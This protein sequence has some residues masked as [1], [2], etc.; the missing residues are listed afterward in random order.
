VIERIEAKGS[1]FRSIQDL[2]DTASQQ[3]KFTLQ[4]LADPSPPFLR[5]DRSLILNTA[6]VRRLV[7]KDRNSCL[8]TLEGQEYPLV[9]GRA[10]L[11]R[12]RAALTAG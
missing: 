3:G 1:F 8:V 4:V 12:L 7:M 10:A 6:R 5:L 2:I 9:L 11:S